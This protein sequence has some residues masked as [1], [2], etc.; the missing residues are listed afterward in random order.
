MLANIAGSN[1]GQAYWRSKK[2]MNFK[3]DG[4]TMVLMVSVFAFYSD[5][6]SLNLAKSTVTFSVA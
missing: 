2:E 4:T 5:D 6:T 3:V 1:T